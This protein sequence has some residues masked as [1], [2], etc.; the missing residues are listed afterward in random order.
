LTDDHFVLIDSRAEGKAATI[1]MI[2]RQQAAVALSGA[3]DHSP[4][5]VA[6]ALE[7]NLLVRLDG[8]LVPLATSSPDWLER[9]ERSAASPPAA[10]S[11]A[12]VADYA[13]GP[14]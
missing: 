14:A 4:E 7:R 13:I 11:Q 1:E 9:F 2:D 12:H 3:R 5:L 10:R 6:W 8:R